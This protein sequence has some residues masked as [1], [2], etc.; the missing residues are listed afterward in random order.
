MAYG[1]DPDGDTSARRQAAHRAVLDHLLGL[2]AAA[3]WSDCVMLRGSMAMAAW[4]GERARE[5]ADLDFVVLPA[6]TV[7]IDPSAPYP[8]LDTVAAVQ[9]WPEAAGGAAGYEIWA[10]GER[11]FETRG[12][13]VLVPPEGLHWDTDPDPV[14]S[15][16]AYED[17]TQWIGKRPEA[18]P[19]LTL[20][21]NGTRRDGGWDYAYDGQGAGGMRILI[22]WEAEGLPPG[23]ARLDFAFDERLYQ[24]P[25]WTRIPRADGGPA[26]VVRTASR[27]L[28]LAWK[29][30]WLHVDGGEGGRP[31]S[32]DLYDAVL[33]AEDERT[34]LTSALLRRVGSGFIRSVPE[35]GFDPDAVPADE[36]D[37][38]AL[39]AD[40][41]GVRGTAREWLGR[42][43]AALAPVFAARGKPI[44]RG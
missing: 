12:V 21:A 37:W 15:I 42:L 30:V 26:P 19:G 39:L 36:S 7:Y 32:K 6:P 13:R 18:A 38:S 24:P 10:D 11:E 43:D 20:D 25:M 27:E 4:M 35:H 28:S 29:L 1:V 9:Q 40:L 8:Y 23:E 5:P 22:P 17:L 41:P 3:P 16:P 44:A 14:G 2:V 31:R 34:R 33:L